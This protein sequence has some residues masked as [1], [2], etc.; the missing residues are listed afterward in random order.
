M[1]GSKGQDIQNYAFLP[2]DR[3][4]LK[5]DLSETTQ[6]CVQNKL[7][8]K[9]SYFTAVKNNKRWKL[10]ANLIARMS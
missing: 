5:K 3:A 8:E 7:N 4:F 6:R 1:L 9:T 2:I 10:I